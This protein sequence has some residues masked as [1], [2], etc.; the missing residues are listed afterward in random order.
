ME[1][2][3]LKTPCFVVDE[4]AFEQNIMDFRR[5]LGKYFCNSI[6][7]YSFKTNSLPYF[8]FM[9]SQLGC[10]AETV[11]DTEYVLARRMGYKADKIIYNGPVKG[12][13]QFFE[14]FRN[15][16]II[17]ID[18]ARE[19]EWLKELSDRGVKGSI[20]IRV[21]MDLEMALP[22]Q[23]AM[24]ESGGRFGFCVENGK[25]AET[26]R[27]IKDIEGISI[28]G[29]HM[30][31]S[32]KS[33]S[34]EVYKELAQKACE[35]AVDEELTLQYLDIGGGFFGG[36]DG[37]SAYE[38]YVSAIYDVLKKNR[39]EKITLI[40]EPGASVVAD[41][42]DYVTEVIDVKETNRS[43]FVITDGT[44]LHIDPFFH[45]TS[46]K[47][48][49]FTQ[50]QQICRKQVLC[51]Y[52]CMEKDRLTE[53]VEKEA[54]LPGDRVIYHVSGA[55]TMCFNPLFI[56]YLPVVYGK[57]NGEYEILREKWG[58]EEYLQK[59]KWVTET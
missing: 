48:S 26:V 7:G 10:Y 52:T 12:K 23:T 20:G 8:I 54:L 41:T 42:V 1:V 58:V 43:R 47:Y 24:G 46:Y 34:I 5:V 35:I 2:R 44:R 22:G 14:A 17:N 55:Y 37:G 27:A 11:S 19:V 25:L 13:E 36:G 50:T 32:S 53:L 29:L 59:C 21:N 30:H 49:V 45:K 38:N 51:G 33:K 28:G 9:A 6:I 40:V 56:E 3:M 57:R 31:V 39:M 16:S 15:R 18:S 4:A